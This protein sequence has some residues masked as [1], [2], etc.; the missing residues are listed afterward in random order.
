MKVFF[1]IPCGEFFSKQHELIQ[2]VCESAAIA[3][4]I[5]EDHSR[6]DNL[7][8]KITHAIDTADYFVADISS[9]SPN[10]ILELG[11]CIKEK[12]PEEFA[13]FIADCIKVPVDLQGF[14]L[15]KYNSIRDFRNKLIQWFLDNV[16]L[17]KKEELQLG[18]PPSIDFIED[19]MDL[20]K[21]LRFWSLPPQCSFKLTHEGLNFTNARFPIMTEHLALLGDYKFSFKAKINRLCVGWIV[22]GT[23]DHD[24]I[25]PAFCVMFNLNQEGVLTPH[26]L[27]Q[28]MIDPQHIYTPFKIR[29]F[30]ADLKDPANEWISIV[31]TIVGDKVTVSVN[32]QT[33]FDENL[34]TEPYRELFNF[35]RIEG[36]VG[37]RCDNWEEAV[38]REVKVEEIRS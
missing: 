27:N 7:W 4:V 37:F 12:P 8:G 3:A 34:N 29:Q 28:H 22:K 32:D 10:V 5:I 33:V 30:K 38:V 20:D 21:F 24:K 6:T 18:E 13:I 36:Q 2:S 1:A 35:P 25:L 9:N 17:E 15:Q 31:T 16:L 14:T 23:R 26:I 11:Y 19:F